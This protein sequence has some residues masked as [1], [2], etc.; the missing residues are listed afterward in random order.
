[1]F[2]Y[3][4]ITKKTLS[5]SLHQHLFVAIQGLGTNC[6]NFI[7]F[8]YGSMYLIS[9]LV[10]VASAN[11]MI[12][13]II[14]SKL[15]LNKPIKL[16]LTLGALIGICGLIVVFRGEILRIDL[17]NEIMRT[18]LM[19]GFILCTIACYCASFGCRTVMVLS[20]KIKSYKNQF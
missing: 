20:K 5:F 2:M 6:A 11:I 16:K 4:I 12:M 13:N 17:N 18:N 1:M 14:N 8:Y 3:C 15:I 7:F 9:G 10:A 19:I